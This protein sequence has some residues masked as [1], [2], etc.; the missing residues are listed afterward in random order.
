MASGVF[1]LAVPAGEESSE[2]DDDGWVVGSV[3]AARQKHQLDDILQSN[4]KDEALK[5][6]LLA[7]NLPAIEELLNS[8][9]SVDST[10]KFGWTPLMY[11]ASVSN[12]EL[13]QILL[14]RG[15]NASFDKDQ[16]T[17][18]MAAC[19]AHTSEEQI[20]KCV[21]LLLSRN[22]NPNAACRKK[23]TPL[24][25]AAREGHPQVVTLLAAHGSEINAQD[26]RGYT[27]LTWAAR[28]GHKKVVF[29]LLE[30]GADKSIQ[31]KD[32][33]TAGEI[34]KSNKHSELF[35][36]LSLSK[37]PF[38]E[39]FN[40]LTKEEA[41]HKLLKAIPNT[42]KNQ[43]TSSY[44]AFGD[45]E[46]FLQGLELEH[47]TEVLKEGE[48]GLRELW[49]MEKKDFTQLGI[50]NTRDQ[51]KILGAA[52]EVQIE[53]VKLEELSSVV[54]LEFSGDEF[55][56]FLV[57]LNKQCMHLTAAVQSAVNQFPTDAHKL[58]LEWSPPQKLANVCGKLVSSAED[59]TGE[60]TK[61][62][63]LMEKLHDGQKDDHC[64]IQ[65]C[66]EKR[67]WKKP[68]VQIVA[69]T[70]VGSGC[71]IFIMKLTLRKS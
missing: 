36:L 29:K 19:T 55:L 35:S 69:V 60:A 70:L 63:S 22:A 56:C 40:N 20:L 32:G 16:Y 15:S 5:K 18:L 39:R 54:N 14:N 43:K 57:K 1:S 30:L 52:K 38:Q 17:V 26:E 64:R 61:L 71:A 66:V 9:V 42:F 50:T 7:G 65:P 24:M 12:V 3:E 44:S 27:A 13:M 34:A 67:W 11:A 8:G 33:L 31:T 53:K 58:V 59:L 23:M 45:L 49:T 48:I 47:L 6:A 41:I 28:Q 51:Q 25:Y 10:F 68:F 37:H 62:K 46:V 2:S 4:D 21:E